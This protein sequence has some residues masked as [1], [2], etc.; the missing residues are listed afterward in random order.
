[1]LQAIDIHGLIQTWPID[2]NDINTF[3]DIM[4]HSSSVNITVPVRGYNGKT[5]CHFIVRCREL[6][7]INKKSNSVNGAS[8]AISDHNKD[9]GHSASLDNCCIIDRS[10]NEL[11]LLIYESLVI[12]RYYPVPNIQSSSIPFVY[13]SSLRLF[14]TY[15]LLIL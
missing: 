3:Q 12:L 14:F 1:M 8:S 15:S 6:L 9:T 10:N 7:G 2:I 5:S 4:S 11:D 13:F